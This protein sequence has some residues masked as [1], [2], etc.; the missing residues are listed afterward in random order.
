MKLFIINVSATADHIEGNRVS[1]FPFW[2]FRGAILWYNDLKCAYLYAM[3]DLGRYSTHVC[4]IF[5][6]Y[7]LNNN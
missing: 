1:L 7:I 5:R 6:D 4:A 3:Y 2:L